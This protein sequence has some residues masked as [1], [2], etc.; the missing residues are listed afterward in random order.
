MP[1]WSV[2][3][4]RARIGGSW[5]AIGRPIKSKSSS[6][7]GGA[8]CMQRVLTM[9]RVV[10]MMSLTLVLIG[11]NLLLRALLVN[12]GDLR[13]ITGWYKTLQESLYKY[14]DYCMFVLVGL[15][16]GIL[17]HWYIYWINSDYLLLT[18]STAL[19]LHEFFPS[20]II[21][22]LGH[23][24]CSLKQGFCL[25]SRLLC[26]LASLIGPLVCPLLLLANF[27]NSAAACYNKAVANML[28]V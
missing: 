28:H 15:L 4:W 17:S 6:S 22:C 24:A 20:T 19:S 5:L 27:G 2:A 12:R 21:L 9:N 1:Q 23:S 8:G 18:I 10:T 3:E 16:F 26:V 7:S 11:V 13:P 25:T 14:L